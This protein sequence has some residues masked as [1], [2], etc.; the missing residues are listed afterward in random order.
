MVLSTREAG[1]HQCPAPQ[2]LGPSH[3]QMG[4]AAFLTRPGEAQSLLHLLSLNVDLS[5]V[6]LVLHLWNGVPPPRWSVKAVVIYVKPAHVA[7]SEQAL[8]VGQCSI[9]SLDW[10]PAVASVQDGRG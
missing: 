10:A 1:A 5:Y 8:S 7:G 3:L 9:S 2:L 4:A 6:T